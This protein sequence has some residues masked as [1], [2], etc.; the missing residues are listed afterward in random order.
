MSFTEIL[1]VLPTRTAEQGQLPI[2]RTLEA[3]DLP[4]ATEDSALVDARLAGCSRS[5]SRGDETSSRG[6]KCSESGVSSPR[7][8]RERSF[9]NEL[10]AAI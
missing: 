1:E 3:D 5:R 7:L 6:V 8:L 10:V 4:L 2:R 9:F